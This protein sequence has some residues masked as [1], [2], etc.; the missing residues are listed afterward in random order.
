MAAECIHG[1]VQ[2]VTSNGFCNLN[3]L[4]GCSMLKAS[5][6]QKVSKAVDHQG[7]GLRNNCFD[8]IVLLLCGANLELLLEEDRC[9]LIIVAYNLVDNIFPVTIDSSIKETTV[10]ERFGSGQVSLSLSSND[11]SMVST[12]I[13]S[14]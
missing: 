10:V 11:L 12:M 9:L 4:V 2:S 13:R 14:G 6:N 7:I 5:L 3:N 1:K 8:N